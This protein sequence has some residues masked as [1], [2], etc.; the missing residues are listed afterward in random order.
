M[1]MHLT[2][3]SNMLESGLLTHKGIYTPAQ[4]VEKL[5]N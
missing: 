5:E 4:S 3:P 2:Q 1:I